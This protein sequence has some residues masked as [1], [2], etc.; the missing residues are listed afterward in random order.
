MVSGFHL[1]D[2]RTLEPDVNV[3]DYQIYVSDTAPD[4]GLISVTGD[5]N[6]C[7]EL[8][9]DKKGQANVNIKKV[10][11]DN[12]V[13]ARY[14]K[15]VVPHTTPTQNAQT[16]KL[17]AFDVLGTSCTSGIGHATAPTLAL[18]ALARA[19]QTLHADLGCQGVFMLYSSDGTLAARQPFN[20]TLSFSLPMQKGLYVAC[21]RTA[22]GLHSAKM[23]I[24]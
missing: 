13:K 14:V 18:P 2:C 1:Y 8:A 11:L 6:T 20:G 19:G 12:A 7:W 21:I 24:R 3:S 4:L 5:S 15:L 17:Y 16:T 22:Q 9:V 23:A 10:T